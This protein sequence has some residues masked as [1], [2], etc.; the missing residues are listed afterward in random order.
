MIAHMQPRSP[1]A[2]L[3]TALLCAVA[4]A[5]PAS[6]RSAE[7]GRQAEQSSPP[8]ARAPDPK[9]KFVA[10][11]RQLM[12]GLAGTYGD[13]K[14]GVWSA[15]ESMQ[16]A[17][18]EWDQA[19]LRYETSSASQPR[20]AD[21]HGALGTIYL[22]RRRVEDALREFAAADQ[23]DPNRADIH[24]L[25]GVAYNL[26][27]RPAEA[28]QAF[29]RASVL[30]PDDP[31]TL[32]RL[33][34]QLTKTAQS[35]AAQNA[36]EKFRESQKR[37]LA[38]S[39][40][41]RTPSSPFIRAE[42]LR[43]T[44]GVA[45]IFS[46]ALYAQGF[47]SLREGRYEQAIARFTE[48]AGV[49]PLTSDS[50]AGRDL[51]M[52]G[53]AALREGELAPAL[54]RLEAAVDLAPNLAEARRVLGMAY[55][56]DEQY[57]NSIEQFKAA[58]RLGPDDERSRIAL[59]DVLVRIG[60]VADAEQLLKETIQKIPASG[61]AYYNLGRLYEGQLKLSDALHEF[62]QAADL[63]PLVGLDHLYQ[64]MIGI[65]L[66][67]PDFDAAIEAGTK[68]IDLN[69]NNAEAHKGLGEI[70]LQQGRHDDALAEF[71]AALLINPRDAESYT[72]I[73]QVYLRSGRFAEAQETSRRALEIDPAQ[74]AA[75]YALATS[76]LRLGRTEEGAKELEHFQQIQAEAQVREQHDWE[77]KMLKQEASTSLEH[78]EYEKTIR[79]L[80]EAIQHEPDEA[81]AHVNLGLILMKASRHEEAIVQFNQAVELNAGLEV[82]R[83]LADAYAALGRLEQSQ[84][85][86]AI[87][88]RMKQERVKKAGWNR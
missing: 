26:L 61:Q 19:I 36:F 25:R 72:G 27:S 54:S 33:A 55:W 56:A 11:L 6:A 1:L 4:L 88:D 40:G 24:T 49:D 44:A 59:S 34:Q 18:V 78:G 75:R 31:S 14:S 23:L 29:L 79:L 13:E 70:D 66:A 5:G 17:L 67:E 53:S 81:S 62:Q 68:R 82:H 86:R 80:Q 43:Q 20:S 83:H 71:L 74:K 10:A 76:L 73:S 7:Q 69:P 30:A 50:G 87:Y 41:D 32:Y 46:P 52:R 9:Q 2:G 35:D 39:P 12:E 3:L 85:Q 38:E 47:T 58:I 42:L 84:Q 15:I 48:A 65:Y 16:S 57:D 45:P 63:N 21:L 28:A 51:I 22:D 64:M 37:K 8:A 60:R 77:L